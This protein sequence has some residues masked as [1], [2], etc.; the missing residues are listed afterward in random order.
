MIKL[1]Y[2]VVAETGMRTNDVMTQL[3]YS[4]CFEDHAIPERSIGAT[5]TGRLHG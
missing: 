2:P 3:N 4:I 5:E 1:I